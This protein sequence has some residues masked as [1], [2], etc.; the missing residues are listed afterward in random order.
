MNRLKTCACV[1][2]ICL[3][4]FAETSKELLNAYE[5]L[6]NEVTQFEALIKKIEATSQKIT[7]K[8]LRENK[9][10]LDLL[11]SAKERE[12][13]Q[14][15]QK[16]RQEAILALERFVKRHPDS[17]QMTADAL[18]QLGHLYFETAQDSYA[19]EGAKKE[20]DAR[21][22]LKKSAKVLNRLLNAFQPFEKGDLA[23]YILA[24]IYGIQGEGGLALR[25]YENL[26]KDFPKS[27]LK[28]EVL[29]RVAEI[30]FQEGR[31]GEAG[32]RYSALMHIGDHNL[33]G[34]ATYKL[35][36]IDFLN[37]KYAAS[38]EGFL[39]VLSPSS[40]DRATLLDE[41]AKTY[42]AHALFELGEKSPDVAIRLE[43][44]MLAKSRPE[45][46]SEILVDL[47]ELFAN[48]VHFKSAADAL[49]SSI[50][51]NPNN[52]KN[53]DRLIVAMKYLIETD[54][55]EVL[56]SLE[57]KYCELFGQESS[58]HQAQEDSELLGRVLMQRRQLLLN[59]ASRHHESGRQL[60]VQGELPLSTDKFRLA[61][62]H[63]RDFLATNPPAKE[64]RKIVRYLAEVSFEISE[65]IASAEAY[66]V[67]AKSAISRAEQERGALGAILAHENHLKVHGAYQELISKTE[68]ANGRFTETYDRRPLDENLTGLLDALALFVSH[69]PENPQAPAALLKM[70]LIHD[71]FGHRKESESLVEQLWLD[72]PKS[73][74]SL[75][76]AN[77]TLNAGIEDR[78]WEYAE[79]MARRF[80]DTRFGQSFKFT[81]ALASIQ[82][83]K[84]NVDWDNAQN[85]NTENVK[86]PRYEAQALAAA[87]GFLEAITTDPQAEFSDKALLNA[88]IAFRAAGKASQAKEMLLRI[89]TQHPDSPV[90]NVARYER[91]LALEKNFQFD[92][93]ASLYDMILRQEPLHPKRRDLMLAIAQLH[94]AS[95]KKVAAAEF[96]RF[97]ESFPDDPEYL[98]ALSEALKIFKRAGD[99]KSVGDI[100]QKVLS[101]KGLSKSTAELFLKGHN[102]LGAKALADKAWA[103]AHAHFKQSV[104]IYEKYPQDALLY[105]AARAEFKLIDFK[106]NAYMA[107]KI[108]GTSGDVQKEQL[109]T[110]TKNLLELKASYE[111]MIKKYQHAI[112]NM[113]ALY[114]IGKLYHNL[115]DSL[116]KAGCPVDVKKSAA[117]DE[118]RNLLEDKAAVLEDKA[119]AAYLK[120]LTISRDNNLEIDW[121]NYTESALAKLNSMAVPMRL[122]SKVPELPL[123]GPDATDDT[124]LDNG[125]MLSRRYLTASNFDGAR[126]I[127]EE[128]AAKYPGNTSIAILQGYLAFQE[129]DYPLAE[130]I[131]K[132]ITASDGRKPEPWLWLGATHYKLGNNSDAKMAF[133]KTRE[134]KPEDGYPSAFLSLIA[135][136]E[137][138]LPDATNELN[139]LIVRDP[140]NLRHLTNRALLGVMQSGDNKVANLALAKERLAQM[141]AGSSDKNE[142]QRLQRYLKKIEQNLAFEKM[143]EDG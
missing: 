117:C 81:T 104:D 51:L 99:S 66:T 43:A 102:Y 23:R 41:E 80:S 48:A 45:I 34:Q 63:Y 121:V 65:F 69:F 59:L 96:L 46:R 97:S 71:F 118:Y 100:Y 114:R 139:T 113:G 21:E 57:A 122:L 49:L 108:N 89:E 50:E 67:L 9:R 85:G 62:Q 25:Q 127:L 37:K 36:W 68:K 132:S 116:S 88:A 6:Q 105:E 125:I 129:A 74:A 136:Q 109:T 35:A 33:T 12:L 94:R 26:L 58:W 53:P 22:F 120:A 31:L 90:A 82:F 5:R 106:Y 86:S 111:A 7:E 123:P 61:S 15:R 13:N 72:Y 93:A 91:A 56:Y 24:T 115:F 42:I 87:H 38:I 112:W 3:S 126:Y 119:V 4:A 17:S 52:S 83:Q 73:K 92:E 134:L 79:R 103:R 133:R 8:K 135:Y 1:A 110:K 47:S 20:G 95:K 64:K 140:H 11:L 70:S 10:S 27:R 16:N 30:T 18:F 84:A 54:Q 107:S 101:K 40:T 141:M 131:F 75:W 32:Q 55:K 14:Q 77:A 142:R 39:K 128:L 78:K 60:K 28:N 130:R 19:R 76:A 98:K 138:R 124:K 2:L 143:T 44:E 29:F 137:N